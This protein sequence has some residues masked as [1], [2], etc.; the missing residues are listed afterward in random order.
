MLCVFAVQVIKLLTNLN[1][2]PLTW[3]TTPPDVTLFM[4][5]IVFSELEV[6]DPLSARVQD[7]PNGP[8]HSQQPSYASG[9]TV[10]RACRT[11]WS[12]ITRTREMC[13]AVHFLCAVQRA[14]AARSLRGALCT[15]RA[16]QSTCGSSLRPLQR[17]AAAAARRT[18]PR[19]ELQAR[20]QL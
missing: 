17:L 9:N 1:P 11:T 5:D 7:G 15:R 6:A 19:R 8:T 14:L 12:T 4:R 18:T 20:E 3:T 10:Q 2:K 16:V 13:T